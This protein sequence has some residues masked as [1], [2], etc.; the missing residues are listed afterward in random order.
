MFN[1]LKHLLSIWLKK[2]GYGGHFGIVNY[3]NLLQY[4]ILIKK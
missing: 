3:R 4:K 1:L 2:T